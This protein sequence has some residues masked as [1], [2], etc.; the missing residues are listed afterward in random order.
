MFHFGVHPQASVAPHQCPNVLVRRLIGHSHS[1][2]VHF[3]I[4]D[5]KPTPEY[6]FYLHVTADIRRPTLRVGDTLVYDNGH[7]T[8]LDSPE[9]LAVAEKYPGRPGLAPSPRSC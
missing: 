6:P 2:N 7:L 8:A 4:C 9:V 1:S 3:H 5:A